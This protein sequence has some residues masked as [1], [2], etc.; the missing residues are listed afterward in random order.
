[1]GDESAWA[2]PI[3]C[4]HRKGLTGATRTTARRLIRAKARIDARYPEIRTTS[5]DQD[6]QGLG[7]GPHCDVGKIS[8]LAHYIIQD[9]CDGV[10][11]ALGEVSSW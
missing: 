9:S 6:L 5:I 11:S 1:L 7:R 2:L 10:G 8:P 4:E 3:S